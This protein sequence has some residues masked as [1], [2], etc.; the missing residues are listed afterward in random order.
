LI[1][2][3]EPAK[4]PSD[5][6]NQSDYTVAKKLRWDVDNVIN[7]AIS[8]AQVTADTLIANSDA[9]VLIFNQYGADFIKQYAKVSPDAYVQMAMQLAYYKLHGTF[10]ATYETA[11]TRLFKDGMLKY[12]CCAS[13]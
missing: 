13:S 10:T 8:D 1:T 2:Y 11:S 6:V 9:K 4:N 5:A 12:A 7:K 3:R